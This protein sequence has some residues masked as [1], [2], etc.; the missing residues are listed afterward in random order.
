M[1]C[2]SISCL[3]GNPQRKKPQK[4]CFFFLLIKISTFRFS[5]RFQRKNPKAQL[6]FS[7][8]RCFLFLNRNLLFFY[9]AVPFEIFICS[10]VEGLARSVISFSAIL[11]KMNIQQLHPNLYQRPSDVEGFKKYT[12]INFSP[13]SN[14]TFGALI[15]TRDSICR[16][17]EMGFQVL[18]PSLE[19]QQ[20]KDW[21]FQFF[22]ESR[23]KKTDDVSE[24]SYGNEKNGLSLEQEKENSEAG[25]EHENG[26]LKL[27][28]RGHW[29]PAEDAKLKELV[30]LYG[31][32]NWNLIAQKL[33]GR[34]GNRN[35]AK[36]E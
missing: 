19:Q 36:K 20:N 23:M 8:S 25:R 17:S 35:D 21:S 10:S 29:R 16:S 1:L 22:E 12:G 28:A 11:E 9:P 32:Q 13:S 26:Q 15:S 14:P 30:S 27:C 2:C 4:L 18:S 6:A 33:E 7:V 24:G 3:Q 34:S 31:P 5:G